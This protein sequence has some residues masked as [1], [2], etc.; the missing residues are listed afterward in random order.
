M[1]LLKSKKFWTIA[2]REIAVMTGKWVSISSASN[3][4]VIQT[5]LR[6]Y[7]KRMKLIRFIF[8][9]LVVFAPPV[10]SA[11]VEGQCS[12]T[13][14]N[15]CN[16]IGN[17]SVY[18]LIKKTTVK[19]NG[20]ASSGSGTILSRNG[21]SYLAIT[22]AHVLT[23]ISNAEVSNYSLLTHDGVDHKISRIDLH[24][25]KDLAFVKFSSNKDY[26]TAPIGEP[27][28]NIMGG[29]LAISGFPLEN[30]EGADHEELC[31]AREY[32][33]GCWTRYSNLSR[34]KAQSLGL[35]FL[36]DP[37]TGN[38]NGSRYRLV[39][40]KTRIGKVSD[41]CRL[42]TYSSRSSRQDGY[43]I[44]YDCLTS[45]GMSGG[46]VWQELDGKL[47][48]VHGLGLGARFRNSNPP[49]SYKVGINMGIAIDPLVV[50]DT[51][52]W[53]DKPSQRKD[54]DI[55]DLIQRT[56]YLLEGHLENK[57]IITTRRELTNAFD[58]I[59][60][61]STN[62]LLK[63]AVS[64]NRANSYLF[65]GDYKLAV[66]AFDE[67]NTRRNDL[68]ASE[69]SGRVKFS[70]A[71]AAF[72]SRIDSAFLVSGMGIMR[73]QS[74]Y[75]DA[76]ELYKTLASGL[77]DLKRYGYEA[78]SVYD[79]IYAQLNLIGIYMSLDQ[80]WWKGDYYSTA[81]TSMEAFANGVIAE[82]QGPFLIEG[83]IYDLT[84]L[85][86]LGNWVKAVT[87][88]KNYDLEERFS[89]TNAS[90][91]IRI[92]RHLAAASIDSFYPDPLSDYIEESIG[93]QSKAYCL[94]SGN[95]E[96]LDNLNIIP[97]FVLNAI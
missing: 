61:M 37:K 36:G 43:N 10:I 41:G 69:R 34:D 3:F 40:H 84:S 13:E 1:H 64:V 45:P 53:L 83:P 2:S 56:Y 67:A 4:Q 60:R 23:G 87:I 15:Y 31:N 24:R 38:R 89:Q 11:E 20:A 5:I 73:S 78:F 48:G 77:S 17:K 63:Y 76:L 54:S 93:P 27:A 52:Q 74:L 6:L 28:D 14:G 65:L 79:T 32:A 91:Q 58:E 9:V 85:W 18:D 71:D 35:P 94:G 29:R 70:P 75:A 92:C 33:L 51:V 88:N 42:Y 81:T 95:P 7:R 47:I 55:A 57:D 46:G 80:K 97:A 90:R 30:L 19:I 86:R 59:L 39:N 66:Q 25:S 82:S 21:N 8:P 16:L 49:I 12:N 72:W 96:F 26:P 50:R 44:S 22:A 68:I 62:P